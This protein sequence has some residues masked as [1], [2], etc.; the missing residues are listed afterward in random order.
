MKKITSILIVLVLFAVAFILFAAWAK[1]THKE[2]ADDMLTVAVT[3]QIGS[4]LIAIGWFL[5]MT[6]KKK[7]NKLLINHATR[8]CSKLV[9]DPCF[10]F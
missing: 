7:E 10:R 6:F 1:L 9:R 3:L 2:Y 4:I 5:F 8:Q